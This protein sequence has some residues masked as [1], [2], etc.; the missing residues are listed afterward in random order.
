MNRDINALEKSQLRQH[1]PPILR[2]ALRD[3]G[4]PRMN[5]LHLQARC[6]ADIGLAHRAERANKT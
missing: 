5:R 3:Q 1:W 4:T 2:V 6:Y